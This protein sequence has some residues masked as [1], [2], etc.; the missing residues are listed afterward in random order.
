M[1][2]KKHLLIDLVI[3]IHY[4]QYAKLS[5]TKQVNN[6]SKT[7][8]KKNPPKRIKDNKKEEG[9]VIDFTVFFRQCFKSVESPGTS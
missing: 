2:T 7:V 6:P 1:L 4:T 9:Y 8:P 5:K 3:Y